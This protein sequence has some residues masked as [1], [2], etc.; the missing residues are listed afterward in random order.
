MKN[1]F[2]RTA[3][4]CLAIM[5]WYFVTTNVSTVTLTVPVE[6]DNVPQELLMLSPS[7]QEVRV[8]ISGPTFMLSSISNQLPTL[9][10]E[11]P[12]QP[13]NRVIIPLRAEDIDLP[14]AVRVVSIEPQEIE[15]NLERRVSREV[16][17][18]VP[19]IGTLRENLKLQSL[20]VA[21]DKIIVSGPE[22]EIGL[23]RRIETYPLDMQEV[24]ENGARTLAVRKPGKYSSI[25]V[26]EVKVSFTIK[27]LL[28]TRRFEKVNVNVINDS[29]EK[30]RFGV[31]P[32]TVDVVVT[33]DKESIHLLR[34]DNIYVSVDARSL[35]SLNDPLPVLIRQVDGLS[36][37]AVP[38]NVR[39]SRYLLL[40][41]PISK[42]RK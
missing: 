20:L 10:R 15:V 25:S 13:G 16:V 14:S 42:E 33:G 7:N 19:R 1:M 26:D 28:E 36:F 35:K 5:L 4:L 23:L 41:P 40:K 17:V 8:K 31:E 6:L 18:E 38:E 34:P 24:S 27:S 29:A 9:H 12:S 37:K 22:N 39:I 30:V 21:P 2:L 11:L 3:S 32:D